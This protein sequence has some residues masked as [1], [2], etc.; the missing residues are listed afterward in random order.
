[1]S[2]SSKFRFGVRIV[3]CSFHSLASP[4]NNIGTK[5]VYTTSNNFPYPGS[6]QDNWANGPPNTYTQMNKSEHRQKAAGS[7]GFTLASLAQ[8]NP[9]T[10]HRI[11]KDHPE[12]DLFIASW[13]RRSHQAP[14]KAQ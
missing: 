8:V 4:L 13:P 2:H 9:G 10:D 11:A 3:Q 12:Q 1:M 7:T 6:Y 14:G 5:K